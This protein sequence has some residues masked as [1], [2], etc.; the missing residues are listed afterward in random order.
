MFSYV[1]WY[2]FGTTILRNDYLSF[3]DFLWS[4]IIIMRE[5]KG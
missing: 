3:F 4:T 1:I 2:P 5:Q